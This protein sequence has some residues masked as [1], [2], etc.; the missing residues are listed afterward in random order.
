MVVCILLSAL[1][2]GNTYLLPLTINRMYF[3]ALALNIPS[4]LFVCWH[5]LTRQ[6]H[7]RVSQKKCIYSGINTSTNSLYTHA[8]FGRSI[9]W[10]VPIWHKPLRKWWHWVSVMLQGK[11]GPIVKASMHLMRLPTWLNSAHKNSQ[12]INTPIWQ[13]QRTLNNTFCN[14]PL[15]S[16]MLMVH[17]G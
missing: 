16:H 4:K 14:I 2:D 3:Y 17:D 15:F 10:H 11:A 8:N 9:Q 12:N 6:F 1:T 13:S 5:T 7:T